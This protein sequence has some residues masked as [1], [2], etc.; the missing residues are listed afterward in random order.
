MRSR[1]RSR[2][3]PIPEHDGRGLDR[4]GHDGRDL[5]HELVEVDVVAQ[6]VG[7]R[8]DGPLGIVASP[9]EAPIHATLHPSAQRLEESGDR[10]CRDRDRER[11]G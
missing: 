6:P 8:G 5:G 3:R 7:E 9:V 10:Q 4:A 1:P 2:L 11:V